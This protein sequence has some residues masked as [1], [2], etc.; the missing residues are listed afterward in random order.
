MPGQGTKIPHASH[1][2]TKTWNRNNIVTN[3]LKAL[4]M[5]HIKKEKE[6]KNLSVKLGCG[7]EGNWWECMLPKSSAC[8]G[9]RSRMLVV[10]TGD[11][12][13]WDIRR[14]II[15]GLQNLHS[16]ARI[17]LGSEV[18]KEAVVL[19]FM[20]FNTSQH[21]AL[22]WGSVSSWLRNLKMF[23]LTC[24][25][26]SHEVY[27]EGDKQLSEEHTSSLEPCPVSSGHLAAGFPSQPEEQIKR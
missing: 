17:D 9:S 10:C 19:F 1:Q 12:C 2:K 26:S 8:P 16:V 7:S 3:S 4:K 14:A 6:K 24:V 5:A 13:C 23:R 25:E 18:V 27:N 20:H 15:R 22:K 11:G 21:D